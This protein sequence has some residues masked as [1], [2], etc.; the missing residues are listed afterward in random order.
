MGLLG[1]LWGKPTPDQFAKKV[2]SALRHRGETDSIEYEA[3]AFTLRFR[4][5][6]MNLGNFYAEYCQ[7]PW[8]QRRS[9]LKHFVSTLDNEPS[10][11]SDNFDEVASSLL[12]RIRDPFYYEAI[13]LTGLIEGTDF[14]ELKRLSISPFH[15]VEV[16]VDQEQA[17][18]SVR[19]EKFDAWGKTLEQVLSVARDNLWKRSNEP[20][21]QLM[22]GLHASDWHDTYD[23]ARMYLHDLVWQLP[24]KGNHV[25]MT[26]TRD[27]L[28]VA[29]TEDTA[30]LTAMVE[31]AKK[32]LE[33]APRPMHGR[34]VQLKG[35]EWIT[36]MPEKSSPNF[37]AF[38]YLE[39]ISIANDYN[40][41]KELLERLHEKDGTDVYV[42]TASLLTKKNHW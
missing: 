2:I 33:E 22:P 8:R 23:A 11:L 17:S 14:P 37:E 30:A 26:P 6:V 3:R 31:L 25:V 29:G 32:I 41:Q 9:A 5:I 19:S 28:L 39:L 21:V 42:A 35:K 20:F 16:V 10:E 7:I 34:A 13:R 40:E 1:F 27:H 24:V 18:M 36:F 38:R 15:E 4:G 12:P